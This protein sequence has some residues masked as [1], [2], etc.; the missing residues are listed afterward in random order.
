MVKLFSQSFVHLGMST[1]V[2][3]EKRILEAARHVFVQQGL[4]G[5]RMQ[6][7]AD[8][9]GINKALLHYYFRT[10]EALFEKVFME[11]LQV[12]APL[13]FGILG[14][15]G[16]LKQK[17]GEFV[18]H[19]IE[20]LKANPYMPLFILNELSQNPE[21][22]FGKVGPQLSFIIGGLG[23]QLRAEAE[24]GNIRPIHPVDMVSAVMG[25]CVFPFLAKP[26][27][28]PIFNLGESDYV[29]FLERRK[30]EAPALIW[31]YLSVP[32]VSNKEQNEH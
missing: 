14:K 5:A 3:T 18:E 28:M 31:A 11:T 13:L 2:T 17:I 22:L 4:K 6:A 23:Q 8:K 7:I 25:L 24:A 19:Y 1:D 27:L 9:A 29:E 21:K 16:P 15:P 32:E 26:L 10:K 20:L 30:K 12:N